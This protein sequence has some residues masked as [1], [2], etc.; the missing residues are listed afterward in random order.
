MNQPLVSVVLTLYNGEPFITQA[1]DSVLSQ[2]YENW[3]LV[4]VNDAST[5]R[6]LEIVQSYK[7]D[8]IR[9]IDLHENVHVCMAHRIGDTAARGKYIAVLDKDDAW[10]NSKLEK[11]VDYMES[12]PETGVCF[13]LPEII[14]ENGNSVTDSPRE[15]VFQVENTTRIDWLH[16]LLTTRN[17]FC[18]SSALIKKEA[19]DSVGDYNILF[20]VIQ[21]YDLWIRIAKR[22][23]LFVIQ[24][25]LTKYRWFAG[26]NSI[27]APSQEKRR[28]ALFEYAWIVGH[29]ITD[30][31][32]DLFRAVF[33]S[34]M[35][36]ISAQTE[37]EIL[38]EKALLLSSDLLATNCKSYA[39]DIFT[40]IFNDPESIKIL[41]EE[42]GIIQHFVY[43]MTGTQILYDRSTVA[44]FEKI[45]K[46]LNN[47]KEKVKTIQIELNNKKEE[48]KTI[49]KELN[50]KKEK[51]KTIQIELNNKKEE[52]KTIKKELNDK[53][54]EIK[55]ITSKNQSL[56]KDNQTLKRDNRS[57]NNQYQQLLARYEIVNT[58]YHELENS[59]FWKLTFPARC[60]SDFIKGIFR[61]I[62]GENRF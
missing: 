27:S 7:D 9:I 62:F 23:E 18:H 44:S 20:M 43:E 58:G 12:H 57:L 38:C 32:A 6:S 40:K 59:T 56:N 14:D 8:R 48:V 42:Y 19:L 5:D 30:M 11:Q 4:I 29:T 41:K 60:V 31:E 39:Y 22:Y 52:V 33:K 2:T 49:Q 47:K 50:S 54:E 1:I 28:R 51:V 25:K 36:K 46:E 10:K 34:E 24:E 15:A 55:T 35:K 13:T 21:D 16:F 37:M 3:E 26:S 45:Q 61:K 17:H 53:T